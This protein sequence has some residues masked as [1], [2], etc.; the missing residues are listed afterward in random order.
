MFKNLHLE[1]GTLLSL[2]KFKSCTR[3][4]FVLRRF[5]FALAAFVG[6]QLLLGERA[7]S[8]VPPAKAKQPSKTKPAAAANPRRLDIPDAAALKVVQLKIQELYG[9][10]LESA[11]KPADKAALAATVLKTAQES[12]DDPTAYYALLILGRELALG[13]GNVTLALSTTKQL[14]EK[15]DLDVIEEQYQ[16]LKKSGETLDTKSP[17][18]LEAA[19]A[20]F[21]LAEDFAERGDSEQALR[22][23]R[24]AHA[25]ATKSRAAALLK[26]VT[27]F[28]IE[29]TA[30][31]TERK[32]L[33]AA[34]QKLADDPA[35]PAANM[36]LGRWHWFR[37]NDPQKAM[38]YLAKTAESPLKKA[39]LAELEKPNTEDAKIA[40]ADQW[41]ALSAVVKEEIAKERILVRAAEWYQ[42]A[43]PELK[44]FDKVKAER[45]LAEINKQVEKLPAKLAVT[46]TQPAAKTLQKTVRTSLGAEL[47]YVPPG[48]FSMGSPENEPGRRK[49]ENQVEVELTRGFY[50]GKYEVT[51]REWKEL[52]G[53]EPWKENG[54]LKEHVKAEDDMP[55][56]HLQHGAGPKGRILPNSATEFCKKLSAKEGKNYRLPTEA[57][58]EYACRAGTKTIFHFGANP[59]LLSEYAWFKSNSNEQLQRVGLKKPNPWGFYDMHGNASEFCLDCLGIDDQNLPGGRDPVTMLNK[60]NQGRTMRGSSFYYPVEDIR[61]AHRGIASDSTSGA[62]Y[63]FRLVLEADEPQ[64]AAAATPA[65]EPTTPATTLS[66]GK[67]PADRLPKIVQTSLGSELIYIPPGKFRMGS[68]KSEEG[69][70]S[71]KE[72]QV[73]V[74]LSRG[75]YM[76]RC[77]VTQGEW[78]ALMGTEPWKPYAFNLG[79]NKLVDNL[80]VVFVSHGMGPNGQIVPDSAAEFCQKLSQRERKK[81]RLPTE[82]EWEYACRGGTTTAYSFPGGDAD[83]DEYAWYSHGNEKQKMHPVGLKKP[84]PFGLYDMHGNVQEWCSDWSN[85]KNPKLL[86]GLDPVGAGPDEHETRV[87]RGG[88]CSAMSLFCRSANRDEQK[89]STKSVAIGFRLVLELDP[90]QAAASA[91]NTG[92]AKIEPPKEIKTGLGAELLYIPAGQFRMG[93][94]FKLDGLEMDESQVDVEISRGFYLGKYEVTQGEWKKLM[95]TE[96]WLREGKP[97]DAVK[98]GDDYPAVHI[99]HSIDSERRL[100]PD[101]ATAFLQKLSQKDGR[102]YRLPTEAEWEYACRAGTTSE[103]S[104]GDDATKLEEYAWWGGE[105]KRGNVKAARHARPVGKLLPNP[106]GLYDMH[107]NVAEWCSD[108]AADKLPGGRDPFGKSSN[109]NRAVRGGSWYTEP[110]RMRSA[111]RGR[112]AL[113]NGNSNL[114]FRIVMED[115]A[116][117]PGSAVATKEPIPPLAAP[118]AAN[119]RKSGPPP[120]GAILDSEYIPESLPKR[121]TLVV[122]QRL[123]CA[124]TF[125]VNTTGTI[126]RIEAPLMYSGRAPREPVQFD[127]RAIRGNLPASGKN[128]ADFLTRG[129]L[130]VDYIPNETPDWVAINVPPVRV[131]KGEQFAL[132]LSTDADHY[133]W[134]GDLSWRGFQNPDGKY[135]GGQAFTRSTAAPVSPGHTTPANEWGEPFLY[136]NP[137]MD[138]GGGPKADFGFRIWIIPK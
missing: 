105:W 98:L 75:F 71:D 133:N 30:K 11:K 50:L 126:V 87:V 96:P 85:R 65:P 45:R 15:F 131:T 110:L 70:R 60:N 32:A 84:N 18:L 111:A 9:E 106:W 66:P 127:I 114:G 54:K 132:V 46:A 58:W 34:E 108:P 113:G 104:Y 136:N 134:A 69:R 120:V 59:A 117:K 24:L 72:N 35:D 5:T 28:G 80:P 19:T 20:S 61:S 102:T 92:P 122:A 83:L 103:Y 128:Q 79:L 97:Y 38:P 16:V 23:S 68:P 36:T 22:F 86:G 27:A 33:P 40:L 29:L 64:P 4:V 67:S 129:S 137:Q 118:A 43:L 47:I 99:R 76:G 107:G 81:Y 21:Q 10:N 73:E 8:Q 3:R 25:A 49:N 55:A 6:L 82:A 51:Q 1:G 39:A 56:C 116:V 78:K 13:G 138:I 112:S 17:G 2:N 52:M 90:K 130:T 7:S 119:V 93:S 44:G 121:Q 62:D 94:R 12:V 95:G 135:D 41:W 125:T 89:Y 53:T 100:H 26:Q 115:P 63:G 91:A 37:Q 74:E 31:E 77:E 88:G 124:Q 57:E 109:E 42:A 14:V 123:T 101:S 48:K